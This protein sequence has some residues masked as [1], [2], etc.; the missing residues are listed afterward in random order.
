MFDAEH[1][2]EDKEILESIIARCKLLMNSKYHPMDS[3][4]ILEA[5]VLLCEVGIYAD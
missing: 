2:S 4:K 3:T 1:N 5:N